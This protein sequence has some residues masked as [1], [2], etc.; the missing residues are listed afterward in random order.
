MPTEIERKFLVEGEAWR[1]GAKGERYCQGYLSRGDGYAVADRTVRVRVAGMR[2]F[3]TIKGASHGIARL[4]YEYEIPMADA[5]EMLSQ[6]CDRPLID[7]IRY[8]IPYQDLLWEVDEFLGE[9]QGLIMAEVEL[10]T[11]DQVVALPD[12]V[13]AEVSGDRRYFNAYLVDHPYSHWGDPPCP[14]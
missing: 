8:K 3:L 11:T 13:G 9:N 6:L 4:E 12:W 7:K 14:P 1:A 5:E 10:E 2:A